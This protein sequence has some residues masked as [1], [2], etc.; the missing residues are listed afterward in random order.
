MGRSKIIANFDIWL[1]EKKSRQSI[2]K[3]P[4]LILSNGRGKKRE[5]LQTKVEQNP[6][7]FRETITEK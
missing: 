7:E 6:N 1:R 2:E 4:T 3:K 5:F